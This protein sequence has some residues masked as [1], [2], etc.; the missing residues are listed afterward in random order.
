MNEGILWVLAAFFAFA[1]LLLFGLALV[2]AYMVMTVSMR[3]LGVRT[4][5]SLRS[6][7]GEVM[8]IPDSQRIRMEKEEGEKKQRQSR[9]RRTVLDDL[10]EEPPAVG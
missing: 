10:D 3:S 1:G 8:Y 6:P 5:M 9:S 4:P 2:C 7:E